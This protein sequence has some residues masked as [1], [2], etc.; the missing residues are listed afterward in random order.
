[1]SYP[2]FEK[3]KRNKILQ[4]YLSSIGAFTCETISHRSGQESQKKKKEYKA[5]RRTNNR[6]F[7][8]ALIVIVALI[9]REITRRY[10]VGVRAKR[11]GA[12]IMLLLRAIKYHPIEPSARALKSGSVQPRVA[13]AAATNCA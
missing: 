13:C 4:M 7:C 2:F 12:Y 1:M 11:S 5:A 9:I 10:P 8:R 3:K 6:E